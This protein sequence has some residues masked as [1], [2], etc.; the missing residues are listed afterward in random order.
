[1]AYLPDSIADFWEDYGNSSIFIDIDCPGPTGSLALDVLNTFGLEVSSFGNVGGNLYGLDIKN[2]D[3][4]SVI[5][6]SLL[7]GLAEAGS[8]SDGSMYEVIA[9]T[10][11]GVKFIEVGNDYASLS[12][13]YYQ[14]Q[15]S[16]YIEECKGVLI[17][18]GKPQPTWVDTEWAPIWGLSGK[19]VYDNSL[20]LSNCSNPAFSTHASI[21]FDD[22]NL[23][24]TAYKDGINNLYELENPFEKIMGYATYQH[25]PGYTKDTRISYNNV[26]NVAIIVCSSDGDGGPYIGN[27]QERPDINAA[28]Q[29]A[30]GDEDCWTN[31][32]QS[33]SISN[34]IPIPIPE[35]LRYEDIR[36]T[37]VDKFQRVV[38]VFIVGTPLSLCKSAP[39]NKGAEALTIP[40]NPD[41]YTAVIEIDS[42]SKHV[43]KL[44]V[45]RDY[46]IVY[47]RS[48]EYIEP[49][50]L[51]A[52][53]TRENDPLTYGQGTSYVIG[54]GGKSGASR[55]G[56]EGI[57]TI[58]PAANNRG[59]I[60]E[61]VIAM[62]DIDTPSINIYDPEY[63]TTGEPSK[64]V[65]IAN[66][67]EYLVRPLVLYEPPATIAFNGDIISQEEGIQDNDPTT[68]QD[69]EATPLELVMDQL[70]GGG[71]L[72]L[73]LS[74][75]NDPDTDDRKLQDLSKNL[76]EFMNHG[77][78][79]ETNYVCGPN[80]RVELGERGPA[81]GVINNITYSYTDQGSY[82]ISVNEGPRLVKSLA[83]GGI[84]GPTVKATESV[85]ARGTVIQNLGNGIHFKVRIDGFGERIAINTCHNIIRKGDVVSC[86]VY[87]NPVEV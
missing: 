45:G 77:T 59:Y 6:L 46:V 25:A 29:Q 78:G 63:N 9:D 71:G 40:P 61:Q 86:S 72:E 20:F 38:D 2:M 1:M 70:D 80:T 19:H 50:I 43:F 15:T 10:D 33:L 18:G 42:S 27:L 39:F 82:T 21:V 14:V 4:L 26:A 52:K 24:N 64:A 12:D 31:A 3:A 13:I 75:L 47:D 55:Q 85:N 60:V 58:F 8:I 81:G 65:D 32:E 51:F 84:G 48:G 34:G 67:F 7:E 41:D 36:N 49:Y 76:F 79:I 87:N 5:N 56:E 54:Q 74:F 23:N 35:S 53:N 83:A 28:S 66:D 62:I 30:F 37:K 22:P 57:A 11:G 17:R 44:N 69:F 16:S 68:Q 73:T